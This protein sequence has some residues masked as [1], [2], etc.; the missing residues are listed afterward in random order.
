MFATFCRQSHPLPNSLPKL[1]TAHAPEECGRLTGTIAPRRARRWDVLLDVGE[2]VPK[3]NSK[4][5]GV[6][7]SSTRVKKARKIELNET[8]IISEF[9]AEKLFAL[10]FANR[11]AR[12]LL[13]VGS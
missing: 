4:S 3:K 8:R 10:H 2:L 7:S 11:M 1:L 5:T 9:I 13:L 12:P 6:N